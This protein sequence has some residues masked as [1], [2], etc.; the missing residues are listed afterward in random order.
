M[1][2][3]EQNKA[4]TRAE[5]EYRARVRAES[6]GSMVSKLGLAAGAGVLG[7]LLPGGLLWFLMSPVDTTESTS[8]T[9]PVQTESAPTTP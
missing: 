5:E 2:P 7:M 8:E 1:Q 4:C 9:V 6:S 3:D